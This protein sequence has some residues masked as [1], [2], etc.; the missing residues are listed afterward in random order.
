MKFR[1]LMSMT[2]ALRWLAA[3]AL[4]AA[5]ALHA[6]DID[7]FMANMTAGSGARP[8]ILVMVDNSANWA[9]EAQKWPDNGGTQGAAEMQA[10]LNV[11][12]SGVI[13]ANMGFAGFTG[14][15]SS[16][17]GYI[18]FGLRDMTV[19]ANKTALTNILT[20]VR[21]NINSSVEKVNDN[22]ES[23]GLYEAYKYFGSLPVFRGQQA[24]GNQPAANVDRSGNGGTPAGARPTA[25]G[26]GLREGFALDPAN[27]A[28]YS[29]PAAASCGRNYVIFVVN[30]A[31]G[32]LPEGSQSYEGTS[33]GAAL[34]L[35]PG[36][37]DTSWTDE[38]ARFLYQQG[39]SVYIL[40]AYNAQHNAAH[41]AVLQR[42]ARVAGGQYYAV[43]NQAQI[44]LAIK[45][46]LAEIHSVSSTFA[47][48]S[49]PISAT[50]RSQNLN[51]VFIGMFRPDG[52]AEPRWVGN[53]KRYQL[54]RVA[55]GV[56]LA[57][58]LGEGAVNLQTGFVKECAASFWT[59]D[60]GSY[61]E[62]VYGNAL[63][64][65]NCS[66][67]P[68]VEG[69]TGS[70]WSDLPDGPAVE[71][72]GVAEV[73]RKGNTPP[74]TNTTPTWSVA[75]NI[76]TYSA[77]ASGRLAEISTANTGWTSG[78]LDW[79]KGWD[80]ASSIVVDG[81]TRYP[82]TEFT[83]TT[84]TSR[85]T[86]PSIHGDVIHSRPLPV[87]YGNGAVTVYYGANDGFMRAVDAETG[88]E[89]WAFVAPE[90]MGRFQRLHDNAPLVN[91]PN[92]DPLL[93]PRPR[94]YFFDGSMG[95]FQTADNSRIWIF[96]SQRRG[97]R[98]LY[99]FDVTN[100]D[101]PQ[102]KWRVGCPNLGDDTGCTPGFDRMGQTWSLPSV[103]YLRG[104]STTTPVVI[105]GG[106]YDTCED[107]NASPSSTCGTGR[108]GAAVFV[109]DA[110]TGERLAMFETPGGSVAADI[111]LADGNADGSVDFAYAAT[112]SGEL[113][114]IDFSDDTL[115]PQGR[116][117]WG[118]RRVAHTTGGGRK[119]LYPP[120]LLRAGTR[121]YL[122]IGSGDREHPL[123]SHYPYSSSVVNRFYVLLDDLSVP[124]SDPAPAV[125]LDEDEGMQDYSSASAATCDVSGVTP[126][127][128]RRGWYM[129]LPGR[130]EQTVTSA[131][132]AAGMVT[133][134]TNRATPGGA[135]ACS[136][137]LGEAR[138]YW[139]NLLNASGAIG[140]GNNIC[141][142]DRSSVFAG[143]GLMPSPTLASVV[144]DGKVETVAI[145]AAQRSG[146]SSS[147]IA[148]QQVKPVIS[149]KR[150]TI[151]WKSDRV[152]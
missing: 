124:A 94:D 85:R 147:G 63:T 130:G 64:R 18:R 80:D 108:K 12:G 114:R 42:A 1:T 17:G 67:F 59:S 75:R 5:P 36:V 117:G 134:N 68:T 136:N 90:H 55:T 76:Y 20:H 112:T 52:E 150:K 32:R 34:P 57:D 83:D 125:D 145:G 65:S 69:R 103:A 142:G 140:V 71:K 77:T 25:Y 82:Y 56:D 143:G 144:V 66:A 98:M 43:K 49:L 22:A 106:G 14:S 54:S 99:G 44:E 149:S 102:L 38:W 62:T 39:I 6:E 137:P 128:G 84:S 13:N 105:V 93:N 139:V 28:R 70:Q 115:A 151:Y 110:D 74:G 146:G 46:I 33:A 41:S 31:Q 100:P 40:D 11:L 16:T 107:A 10:L 89:R 78:L 29:G 141:G 47:T 35:L 15:G 111:A 116:S 138:G 50:N 19:A 60:S 126:T 121:M 101:A 37:N 9:R 123:D 97:G 120:A 86:R 30:N 27:P 81:V 79:V 53:L 95:L 7:I 87:N 119:F 127:S 23:A 152:D 26:Q 129:N 51:Q 88:R 72:G 131:L 2:R 8:N 92:V 48:A 135:N 132:I 3:G 45:Q 91:Y 73:L 21:N 96:A 113:W 24:S 61:W 122:A 104:H 109:L 4:A 148:P 118:I 58:A 133:F